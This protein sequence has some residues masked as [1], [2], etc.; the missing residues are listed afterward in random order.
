MNNTFSLEQKS[1]TGNLD[2]ILIIRQHK[3]D[4]MA[5]FMEIKSNNPK[6]KQ[7]EIAKEIGYS[8]STLQRDWQDIKLQSL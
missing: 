6:M 1:R 2:A 7:K 5:R 4:L 3:L 8:T